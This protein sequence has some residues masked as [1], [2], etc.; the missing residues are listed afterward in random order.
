MRELIARAENQH[1]QVEERR[2]ACAQSVFRP[3]END[4]KPRPH[5]QSTRQRGLTD[6]L[7]HASALLVSQRSAAEECTLADFCTR[8]DAGSCPISFASN[9]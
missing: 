6:L 3:G 1:Q 8:E 4:A 9:S 7:I 2:L 5:M